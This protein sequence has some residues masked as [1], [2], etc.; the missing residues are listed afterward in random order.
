MLDYNSDRPVFQQLADELRHQIVS[1]RFAA[2]S[3]LP[4]ESDLARTYG[5]GHGTVRMAVAVLTN[6]GLVTVGWV[7]R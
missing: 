7:D 1:G 2:G 6:E 5:L 4:S 3:Q